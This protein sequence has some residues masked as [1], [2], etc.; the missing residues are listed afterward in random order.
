MIFNE[1][2]RMIVND[3]SLLNNNI[4]LL[5]ENSVGKTTILREMYLKNIEMSLYI[6]NHKSKEDLFEK[7]SL[8]NDKIKTILIDNID[9]NLEIKDKYTILEQLKN[10]F[11]NL[12][13]IVSTNFEK[14]LIDSVD[15]VY[16]LITNKNYIPKDSNDIQSD[17]DAQQVKLFIKKDEKEIDEAEVLYSK[18]INKHFFGI[19]AKNDIEEIENFLLTNRKLYDFQR[20]FFIK[21]LEKKRKNEDR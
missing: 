1:K 8:I 16:F 7:I 5:G 10:K 3:I 9:V 2:I 15:C 14:L 11:K 19:I 12:R 17:F 20:E 18:I 21:T 4:I 6:E 13:F